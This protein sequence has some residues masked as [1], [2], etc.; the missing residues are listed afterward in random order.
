MG[1]YIYR[2]HLDTLSTVEVVPLGPSITWGEFAV[3]FGD[4][5]RGGRGKY[6][7]DGTKKTTM[8][9]LTGCRP[10]LS[11]I[12]IKQQIWNQRI[13]MWHTEDETIGMM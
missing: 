12:C 3:C 9:K 5:A 2:E 7:R 11:Y 8:R 10:T 6:R 4:K 1:M 13:A